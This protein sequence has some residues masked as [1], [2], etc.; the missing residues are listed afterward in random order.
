MN[1]VM[2]ACSSMAG[3]HIDQFTHI[4]DLTGVKFRCVWGGWGGHHLPT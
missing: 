4:I 2:P 3:H 1:H